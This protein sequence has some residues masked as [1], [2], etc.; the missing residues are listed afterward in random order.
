MII[1]SEHPHDISRPGAENSHKQAMQMTYMIHVYVSQK[2]Q[3]VKA[4]ITTTGKTPEHESRVG[5]KN[6]W[7]LGAGWARWFENK[8]EQW[9]QFVS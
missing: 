2:L 7:I 3:T 5:D 8:P 9:R 6:N 1:F 4:I